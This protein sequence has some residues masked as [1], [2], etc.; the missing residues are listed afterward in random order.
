[1]SN[2]LL[3]AKRELG[4]YL[5]SLNGYIIAAVVLLV[6]GILFNYHALGGAGGREADRADR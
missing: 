1:M 3:I 4:A 6:D 5:R 2:I